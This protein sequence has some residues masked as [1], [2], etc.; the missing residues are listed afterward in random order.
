M[1]TMF[2]SDV[3]DFSTPGEGAVYRFLRQAA[4]PDADFL[5][6]YSPDIE[7]REPDFILLS[8]DCGLIVLEVKDWLAGQLLEAD[9]KTALLRMGDR[10]ER[11]KQPL[12]QAREYVN[13]LMSLLGRGTPGAKGRRLPCPVTWGA[14]FPHMRREEFE[15]SGLNTVMDGT[16]VLCWDELCERSP[17][18]CDASG[19]TLRRWLQEHFP[20]LF[21]FS[22]SP[23]DVHRLRERIFPV[24]RLDLPRRA[25]AASAQA[26]AVLALDHEQENLARSFGPGKNL[27]T[28]PS[29]SGKTLILAHQA[30]H[31][32]RVDKR[33]RRVLI[34]CFNLSLV[35]YIRRLLARKGVSLG[36]DGVEVIP[37]YSLCERILGEPLAHSAETED[38][39][40]L[41]V[42]ETLERLDGTHPL[43]KYWDAVLVD[44]GQDFSPDMAQVLLR[45]VPSHGTLNVAQDENQCLYRPE[46]ATWQHMGIKGLKVRRLCRQYRNTKQ[47]ARAAGLALGTEP[48]PE[49][50]AG[51]DGPEPAWLVSPDLPAQ[52]ADVAD[53]VARLAHGG[54]PMS[55]IAVLYVRSRGEG[56]ASLPEALLHAIEARG[57]LAR[58]AARDAASK[59]SFDIT[60]DSVTVS[61]IHSAK[62]LDFAHVFLLGLDSLN[63]EKSQDRRLAHVGLT[64][65]R[66][67][68]TLAV[69]GRTGWKERLKAAAAG[70]SRRAQCSA[71]MTS[72]SEE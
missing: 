35:G 11:R 72:N 54:V 31:L 52:V 21:D 41:V 69:C 16:R 12:A 1:A 66:E 15:A 18:L 62:G 39:Y 60:T 28:G 65:A 23:E 5:V 22:L 50:L 68:L 44:E 53:A 24:V 58:W 10:E 43:Q 42:Q 17:L 34:T 47:I 30:W 57:A 2:P 37:F 14:V 4:R 49:S 48:E 13:N 40:H 8:P 27:I 38:F 64:R 29:G 56:T 20:P 63:P 33:V 36:R 51:A 70:F 7:D 6:W 32:P 19:Q 46:A 61:T 59:R 3:T 9:P 45:L 55:E 71:P 26:Q 25:A 67:S